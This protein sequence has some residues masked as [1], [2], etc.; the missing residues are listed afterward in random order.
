LDPKT[1]QILKVGGDVF[2][3][4]RNSGIRVQLF[5]SHILTNDDKKCFGMYYAKE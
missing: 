2:E 5:V 1:F 4:S 3:S